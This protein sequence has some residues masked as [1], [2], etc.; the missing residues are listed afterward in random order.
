MKLET[1]E[2]ND[3]G[4]NL[5]GLAKHGKNWPV[6]YLIHNDKEMYVGETNSFQNRFRQHLDN[7]ARKFLT[8]ISFVDDDEFNKSA[9]LD[10]EQ[11]LIRLCGADGKFILQNKNAGQ[12]GMHNYFQRDKYEKKIPE[13][14]EKM[15]EKNLTCHAYD[16][17]VNSNLFKYSPYTTPTEE[18]NEVCYNVMKQILDTLKNGKSGTSIVYGS[19]GTGK[20]I[21]AINLVYTLTNILLMNVDDDIDDSDKWQK[22]IKEWKTYVQA[23]DLPKIAFVVPMQSLNATLSDVFN[24]VGGK[25]MQ[26][27]VISPYRVAKEKF[28][29]VIVDES[30]RLKKRKSLAGGFE[31]KMFDD[32]CKSLGLDSKSSNQLEW[33]VQQSRHRVLFYDPSQ[34][35]KPAD[36]YPK[37]YD[38]AIQ[39]TFIQQNILR[40]QMRCLG[41]SDYI[42][43]IKSIFNLEN[44]SKKKFGDYDIKVFDDV[45]QMVQTIKAKDSE[46]GL[47]RNLAGYAWKWIS[48]D[49][50]P[51]EIQQQKLYDIKIGAYQYYWNTTATNW[52]LSPNAVNE[53]GCVHTSQGY[54]LNIVGLIFGNEIDWDEHQN[55]FII[56]EKEFYDTKV[57]MDSPAHQIQ[58]HIINA[59][60]VM[61]TRGIKGCY[62]YACKP[63]MKKFLEKWFLSDE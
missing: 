44:V 62:M 52:I 53:I 32:C 36:I 59:Y 19:A 33:I 4:H 26:D 61:I 41:G 30:H 43:Y 63:G 54:D 31:Y 13:I 28:D 14:W 17:L 34:S 2:F 21:V 22:L 55:C 27:I 9:V 35:I 39:G 25:Q 24:D 11:G 47:C 10:I 6:V 58:Q 42:D 5:A 20:T 48:K 12:S 60:K 38:N 40:S 37:E 7:D 29:V 45:D 3:N 8:T 15:S 46:I 50:K 56:N 1:Y 23:N 57:K 18:Q 51:Q 16:E 49:Y